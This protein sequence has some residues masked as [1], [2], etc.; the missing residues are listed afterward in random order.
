MAR[1]QLYVVESRHETSGSNEALA[2]VDR[3]EPLAMVLF[4]KNPVQLLGNHADRG[5]RISLALGVV[6]WN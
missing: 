3:P 2:R 6:S 4:H 5:G 1:G